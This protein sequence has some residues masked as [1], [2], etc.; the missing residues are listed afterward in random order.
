L[1]RVAL[2]ALLALLLVPLASASQPVPAN[3]C[4]A[5]VTAPTPCSGTHDACLYAFSWIPQCV[6]TPLAVS[7]LPCGTPY[8]CRQEAVWIVRCVGDSLGGHACTQA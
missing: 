1:S 7:A 6:D 5:G 3:A 4:V 2:C 8:D